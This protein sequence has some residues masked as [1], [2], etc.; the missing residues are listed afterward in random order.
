MK[1]QAGFSLLEILVVI[2]IL[3]VIVGLTSDIFMQIIKA[4]NKSNIITEIKQN[5]D[6]ANNK[7]ER[8]L[9]NAEEIT[10]IGSKDYGGTW[11]WDPQPLAETLKCEGHDICAIIVK[12]AAA[13]AGATS[14]G[15]TKI[16][17]NTEKDRECS[18]APF[19]AADQETDPVSG[20]IQCNGNIRIVTD[21][22]SD[23]ITILKN[24]ANVYSSDTIGQIITNTELR[25]GVSLDYTTNPSTGV[26]QPIIQ[27]ITKAGKPQ[28]VFINYSMSQGINASSRIDSKATVPFSL[29]ISLRTY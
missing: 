4:S 1:K 7:L 2:A 8:I 10:T 26:Q 29:T 12:N 15:Y 20:E 3:G 13:S 14:G 19:I 18:I 17:F 21:T 25:S 6:A 23:A 11:D 5:G 27:L 24:E 9:R 16:Q 22:T 28:L